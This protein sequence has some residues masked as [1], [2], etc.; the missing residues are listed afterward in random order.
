LSTL[1]LFFLTIAPN[2]FMIKGKIK[3]KFFADF[4]IHSRFSRATSRNLVPEYLDIWARKKGIQVIGTG[5]FT[6]PGWLKELEEKL[7]PAEPGLFKLKQDCLLNDQS[8]S[9]N[10]GDF[11]P[12]FMLTAEISTIY[13][14]SNRVRKIHHLVLSPDFATVKKIQ[15]ELNRIKANITSDGRPIIG[16]DSRN[17]LEMLLSVSGENQLIPAH[18]W[19]PWFSV[20]GE[21]SGFDSIE[22][23]YGDLSDHIH[24]VETGLSSDPPMNRLCGFLDQY[25]LISNSDAHSPEKLGREANIFDTDLSYKSIIQ[26]IKTGKSPQFL[27]TVEFFPQEGKYHYDGHRKCGI[28][29]NPAETFKNHAICPVCGK[30]VTV[31]VMNRVMQLADKKVEQSGHFQPPFFPVIPLKEILSEICGVGPSSK[32]VSQLYDSLI[33]SLGTEFDILL[34]LSTDEI[35]L[36]SNHEISEAISRMRAGDVLIQEGFDGEFGKIRVLK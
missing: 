11:R 5:D 32:R 23:C 26:A 31:G 27:G 15:R 35:E 22:E 33:E 7:L 24:A 10:V 36:K 12:R 9:Q 25:T 8:D 29:W 6:H 19:T 3:M 21:K 18:I 2:F 34:N 16:L 4:H 28:C 1:F 17:L 20:L 30:K 14:R 13:K